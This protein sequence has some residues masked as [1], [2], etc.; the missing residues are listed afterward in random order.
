MKKIIAYIIT[1]VLLLPL[2]IFLILSLFMKLIT[3]TIFDAYDSVLKWAN[4]RYY[5]KKFHD[6]KEYL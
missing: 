1:L 3:L 6:F 2:L 5:A 4:E